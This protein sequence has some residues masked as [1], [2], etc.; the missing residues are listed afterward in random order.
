MIRARRLS[1]VC[2]WW[3][4]AW[5]VAASGPSACYGA[6]A[7]DPELRGIWMHATQMK[8]RAE[9]DACVQ[10]IDAANLNAVFV[11]VWYWGGQAFYQSRL[12]PMGEGVEAGFDPLGYLV[13]SC[14]R[15]KIEVHAW[16]V[17]GAYG[18]AKPLHVL[19]VHPDWA[20]EFPGELW[21]DFGKPEV[22][23]FQS[24]LMVECL[25]R[26]PIDGIHFDYI[27]YPGPQLCLCK[28]CQEEFA[29]EYGF[30]PLSAESQG[31]FP[32]VLSAA[33]NPVVEPTTAVVAAEFAG[34]VPAIAV[35]EWG[36]GNVLLLNWHAERSMPPAVAK[37]IQRAFT[38]WGAARDKVFVMTTAPTRERYGT[39]SLTDAV[40]SL[41]RL[42]F[43]AEALR[44]DRLSTL[45][46]NATLVL[47]S[48]YLIPDDVAE[49]IEKF[50]EAGGT[51][52][53]ID[54]PVFSIGKPAVQRVLGMRKAGRYFS[55]M[56][57]MQATGRSD[58]VGSGGPGT[59]KIDLQ[60][61]KLRGEK[62][63]EYRKKGVT[64]LVRDVYRRAKA[65]KPEAQVTA[66]VFT[67][68][69][70]AENVCQ[71]WPGWLREG[72]V[73]YVIP[74]AYT[75]DNDALKK[76]IREWKTVD[77]RLERIVPGLSIYAKTAH[78]PVT[79]DI[80]LILAQHR[81]SMDENAHGNNYF[82]LANLSDPLIEAFKSGPYK[83]KVPAY[84]PPARNSKN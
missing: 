16:F 72:I 25:E 31:S 33:G 22:R 10:R 81:L 46:G 39:D 4:A 43:R 5:I 40:A 37:T 83:E 24:D 69:A 52:L 19:D 14:H 32:T 71:D 15:R 35:N 28:H 7:P 63:I 50:V 20:V 29:R 82:S 70:S 38:R 1:A 3:V 59:Q 56:Q 78:G 54:G 66:A 64:A 18:R 77:P 80:S 34:G 60:R 65:V 74:M 68:L 6:A 67:P 48:V 62:W 17:N 30:E 44:E 84:R 13:E 26:Y 27:R 79:R 53:V 2:G 11:L 9:A 47:P 41:N 42:G 49:R 75:M 61:E 55:G 76:Q 73:D 57:V 51:L 21:Y 8:T 12:C 36:K 23:K 58:L 45:A